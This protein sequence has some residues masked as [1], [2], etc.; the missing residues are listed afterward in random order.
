M[1]VT[2]HPTSLLLSFPRRQTLTAVMET[3]AGTINATLYLEQMVRR[4]ESESDR[5]GRWS[6]LAV[7]RAPRRPRCAALE[8]GQPQRILLPCIP[9]LPLLPQPITVSNFVDLALTGF[10]NG[11][12]VRGGL[13]RVSAWCH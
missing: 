12:C 1:L 11:M 8:R 10:Y 7:R 9:A 13:V 3:T 2:S 4:S 6:F 5:G